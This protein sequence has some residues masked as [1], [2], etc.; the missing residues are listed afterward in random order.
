MIT[1]EGLQ[2]KK[3][4][5]IGEIMHLLTQVQELTAAQKYI[6]RNMQDGAV[7]SALT[8]PVELPPKKQHKGRRE[9]WRVL[10]PILHA[11]I[12]KHPG[13]TTLEL[14]NYAIRQKLVPST[15]SE[16]QARNAVR[17][18]IKKMKS[19]VMHYK[20]GHNEA[21]YTVV[22]KKLPP[23][24]KTGV[25]QSAVFAELAKGS[26]RTAREI[27]KALI[28]NGLAV[29]QYDRP[30]NIVNSTLRRMVKVGKLTRKGQ[31]YSMKPEA[32]L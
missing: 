8:Q 19:V 27:T 26:D 32:Q 15:H 9:S 11:Y 13:V 18:C 4:E 28:D 5:L 6:A 10:Q 22:E 24:T 16:R 31:F 1:F 30:S 23:E 21:T 20:G 17:L 7:I 29:G 14:T 12:S 3:D 2:E 25:L